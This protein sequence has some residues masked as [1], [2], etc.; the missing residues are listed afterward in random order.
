MNKALIC[1]F[2]LLGFMALPPAPL[3][4]D[5]VTVPCVNDGGRWG[6]MGLEDDDFPILQLR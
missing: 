2:A 5:V 4:A 3:V 6:Y 1:I